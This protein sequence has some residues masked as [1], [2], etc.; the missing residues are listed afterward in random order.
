MHKYHLKVLSVCATQRRTKQHRILAAAPMDI[1]LKVTASQAIQMLQGSAPKM[2]LFEPFFVTNPSLQLH[3][4]TDK[5]CS[6]TWCFPQNNSCDWPALCAHQQADAGDPHLGQASPD[7]LS[8]HE[9]QSVSSCENS[10]SQQGPCPIISDIIFALEMHCL[11]TT[12]W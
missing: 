11:C 7:S 8:K 5:A 2:V 6:F 4:E 1:G 3:P 12:I 10:L 9:K